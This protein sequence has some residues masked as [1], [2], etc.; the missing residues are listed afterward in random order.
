MLEPGKHYENIDNKEV[1]YVHMFDS[2]YG[3][4][5]YTRVYRTNPNKSPDKDWQYMLQEAAVK[6]RPYEF[7]TQ[8]IQKLFHEEEDGYDDN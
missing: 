3:R 1:I 7:L 8:K 2:S 5:M 6:Y 4:Y